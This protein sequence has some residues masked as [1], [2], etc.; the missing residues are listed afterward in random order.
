LRSARGVGLLH[1]LAHIGLVGGPHRAGEAW[2]AAVGLSGV[3]FDIDGAIAV[4]DL[5]FSRATFSAGASG[6]H[7]ASAVAGRTGIESAQTMAL[8]RD[9]DGI[10]TSGY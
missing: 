7:S 8:A 10:A 4:S 5:L 9:R 3:R 1:R 6:G 2:N